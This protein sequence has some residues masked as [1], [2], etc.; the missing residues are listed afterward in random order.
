MFAIIIILGVLSGIYP[1]FFL[2][3]FEPINALKGKQVKGST[4][5]Y[6]RKGL[7]VVQFAISL[8]MIIATLV[9]YEQLDY[10]KNRDLGFDKEDMVMLRLNTRDM[11]QKTEILKTELLTASCVKSVT[12]TNSQLGQGVGKNL[13]AVE[14]SDG[15]VEKGVNLAGVDYDFITTMNI[16]ILEGRT[17]SRDFGTDTL[18]LIVNESIAKRFGWD[19]PIGKKVDFGPDNMAKVIDL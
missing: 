12:S 15:M 1:S 13:L 5:S 8:F 11:R 7:V 3:R 4:H 10:L 14:T 6:L 16:K 18:G 9:V 19:E 2:A 17:H